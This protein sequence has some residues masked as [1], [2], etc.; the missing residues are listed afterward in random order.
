[1]LGIIKD[2][3]VDK[4]TVAEFMY[5][6]FVSENNEKYWQNLKISKP[7]DFEDYFFKI[8]NKYKLH[9]YDAVSDFII[10]RFR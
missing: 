4:L 7:D 6:K 8:R 9:D 2:N 5:E 10:H 3:V 1:M